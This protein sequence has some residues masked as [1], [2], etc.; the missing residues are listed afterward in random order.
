VTAL[1]LTDPQ[2]EA[3]AELASLIAAP[4]APTRRFLELPDG[5]HENLPLEV[6]HER[7]LGVA[8]KSALDLVRRS[9]LHYK[10]WVDGATSEETEA[11]HFGSALHCAQ[12]EPERF[13][14][15]YS[16]EPDFGDCRFKEPKARRDQWRAENKESLKLSAREAADIRGM[17]ASV[18]AHPV[19]GPMLEQGIT[20]VT[21][22]WRDQET[23]L[24]CKGRADHWGKGLS[25]C[26]DLKSTVDA[27]EYA[28]HRTIFKYGYDKQCAFYM[29]GFEACGEPLQYF[30]FCAV[31]K[32]PP[33][34]VAVDSCTPEVI[35]HARRQV[36][37]SMRRLADCLATGEFPGYSENI[38]NVYLPSWMRD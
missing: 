26:A 18:R 17:V 37:E 5:L 31:E 10:S 28:F 11:L 22:K 15:V 7:I 9:P 4:L 21:L 19:A 3:S 38:R 34:A 20:E 8:S 25:L 16:A 2:R 30:I 14:R 35:D 33:Y 12:L 36:R 27:S 1:D 32:T 6:Y 24:T 23:G 29:D 13:A